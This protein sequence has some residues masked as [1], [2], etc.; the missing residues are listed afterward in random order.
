MSTHA[1]IAIELST[2]EVCSVYCHFDGYIDGLGKTLLNCYNTEIEVIKL[3]SKGNASYIE[4]SLDESKFYDEDPII[5]KDA[6][7]IKQCEEY[8]YL[9]KGGEWYVNSINETVWHK[10]NDYFNINKHYTKNHY[11]L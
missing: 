1:C 5:T 9:F 10:L 4:H 7:S 8:N 11:E 3:I 2:G 6:N